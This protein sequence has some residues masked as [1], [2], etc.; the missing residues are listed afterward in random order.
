MYQSLKDFMIEW[1]QQHKYF[2]YAFFYGP[3]VNRPA[4]V[5]VRYSAAK[6]RD[7]LYGEGTWETMKIQIEAKSHGTMFVITD[8]WLL[9]RGVLEI[10]IASY[11]HNYKDT[12][13]I[14]TLRWLGENFFGSLD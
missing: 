13:I 1:N 12:Y 7:F 9:Q 8:E 2:T 11:N 10:K 4:S 5:D 14:D 6:Y 3:G